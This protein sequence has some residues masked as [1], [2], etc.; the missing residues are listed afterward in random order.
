MVEIS[1]AMTYR[2]EMYVNIHALFIEPDEDG[3]TTQEYSLIC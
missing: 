1:S 3:V 2:D